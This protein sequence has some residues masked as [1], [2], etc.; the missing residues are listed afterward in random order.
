MKTGESWGMKTGESMK[1]PPLDQ[2][3][4]ESW[5]SRG[6]TEEHELEWYR[7][8]AEEGSAPAQTSLAAM[9]RRA[10]ALAVT[11]Q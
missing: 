6:N 2:G 3:T 4:A 7:K 9:S 1:S 10:L 5:R 8:A 11:I